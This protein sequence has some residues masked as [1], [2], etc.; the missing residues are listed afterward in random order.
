MFLRTFWA[1]A[2]ERALRTG[3]QFALTVLLAGFGTQGAEAGAPELVN[4][5]LTA[6]GVGHRLA[7]LGVAFVLGV[8]V[9]ILTS[10]AAP[11][12]AEAATA[13]IAAGGAGGKVRR[14]DDAT[15]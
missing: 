1:T 3:A 9:S 7:G 4:E 12:P 6:G 5:L 8:V 2:T 13:R 14:R 11:P 15:G 10:L